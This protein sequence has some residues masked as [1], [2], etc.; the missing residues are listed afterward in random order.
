MSFDEPGIA[1]SAATKTTSGTQS[2]GA[3]F[4]AIPSATPT[5]AA[6]AAVTSQGSRGEAGRSSYSERA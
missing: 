1:T 6:T 5:T 3:R 2:A 4:W